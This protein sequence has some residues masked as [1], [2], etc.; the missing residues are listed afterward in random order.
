[1]RTGAV[2]LALLL[3]LLTRCT[4]R[5]DT[6]LPPPTVTQVLERYSGRLMSL[7]GV[8]GTAEGSCEGRPCIVVLVNRI[9]PALERRLPSSLEGIPVQVRETG[10]V[11]AR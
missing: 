2:A 10:R 3:P 11:Q 7:R 5:K 4:H 6:D 8:V 1:V 9:T